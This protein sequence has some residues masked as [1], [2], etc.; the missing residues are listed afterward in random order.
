MD[1]CYWEGFWSGKISSGWTFWIAK[2]WFYSK[3]PILAGITKDELAYS[4]G[5]IVD[6][7]LIE[8]E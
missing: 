5:S 1:A 7:F 3:V 8:F 4:A 6:K 2:K